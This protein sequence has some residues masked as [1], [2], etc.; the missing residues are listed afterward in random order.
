MPEKMQT[1]PFC[2]FP[3]DKAKIYAKPY[4]GFSQA[5]VALQPDFAGYIKRA[6]IELTAIEYINVAIF[7]SSFIGLLIA[8]IVAFITFLAEDVGAAIESIP[9]ALIAGF[10]VTVMQVLYATAYPKAIASRFASEVESELP[11]ALRHLLIEV[12]SGVPLYESLQGVSKS[13][14]GKISEEF[15]AVIED[16]DSGDSIR[17]AIEK[18]ATRTSSQYMRRILWQ[19]IDNIEAGSDMGQTLDVIAADVVNHQKIML[20]SYAQELNTW[21]LMYLMTAVVLPSMGIGVMTIFLSFVGIVLPPS[22][23]AGISVTL[24]FIQFSFVNMIY[25]RKPLV[26]I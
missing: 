1:L 17:V 4:S 6:G 21:A 23:Y 12:K 13:N 26:G 7:G 10:L 18:F 19:M 3:L 9:L 2:P 22:V 16:V 20:K 11:L 8:F 15:N 5:V 25:H 14:Y 24:A